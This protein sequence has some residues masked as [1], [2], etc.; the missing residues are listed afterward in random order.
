MKVAVVGSGISG[1][2]SAWL[3]HRGGHEV[4]LIEA[5][6]RLGGH[7]HTVPVARGG[8]TWQIDTGFIV[9]NEVNYPG[10]TRLLRELGVT[11]QPSIMSF[12]V[13]DDA[14]GFEYGGHDFNSLFAQRRNLLNP[15]HWGM[16]RDILRFNKL[17]ASLKADDDLGDGETV[18]AFIA[19]HNL[20][21][22]FRERYLLPMA[23]AIWSLPR[24]EVLAV[25]IAF[26]ARFMN[27]HRMLQVEGR[28]EWRTVTGGSWTYVCAITAP[29]RERIRTGLRLRALRRRSTEVSLRFA[30]GSETYDAVVLAL[31]SDQALALLEDPS[32][33]E[34]Q[35]LGALPYQTNT[36]VLHTDQR[37]LPRRS[38]ARAAWNAHI[39][40]S[41]NDAAV[42]YDLSTLQG[43]CAPERFLVTL[44]RPAAMDPSSIIARMEYQHPRFT[45]GAVAARRRHA[46]I[47]GHRRTYF[48]GAY[49]GYGFHED[50][51]QSAIRVAAQLGFT[52]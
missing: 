6:H 11:S 2:L 38:A 48:A 30:H 43:L 49:W 9:F 35:I 7:T 28:P 52:W 29:F 39:G 37:L 20:G 40:I 44:G 5:D 26:V 1:L 22:A 32:A 51:V 31:H 13:R 8:R 50:G 36:A 16:L 15:R 19:R 12:S 14:S 21:T 3:L 24:Q 4:W 41:G 27:N 34:E 10:F 33:A 17:A 46:E 18:G 45:P 47:S 42:T 25:P 23:G